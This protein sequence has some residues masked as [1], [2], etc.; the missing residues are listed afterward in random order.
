MGGT[1]VAQAVDNLLDYC[2]TLE[3][4]EAALVI[5]V[6][7]NKQIHA[8]EQLDQ[9]SELKFHRL[10]AAV[11]AQCSKRLHGADVASPR[12]AGETPHVKA[13]IRLLTLVV[14]EGSLHRP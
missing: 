9:G 13:V 12:E 5:R 2:K 4:D 7:A 1:A 10:A 14:V 8:V 11:T 6:L 3:P